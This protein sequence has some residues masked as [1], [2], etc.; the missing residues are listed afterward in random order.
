MITFLLGAGASAQSLPIGN[1]LPGALSSLADNLTKKDLGNDEENAKKSSLIEDL[2]WLAKRAELHESVDSFAKKVHMHVVDRTEIF[3][4]DEIVKSIDKR[5]EYHRLKR[6]LTSFFVIMQYANVDKRYN[7]LLSYIVTKKRPFIY[8]IKEQ[9]KIITWNYDA[10]IEI[11]FGD[12]YMNSK[13]KDVFAM[14]ASYPCPYFLF[15]KEYPKEWSREQD[16]FNLSVMHLN[17][18]AGLYKRSDGFAMLDIINASSLD[19]IIRGTIEMYGAKDILLDFAWDRD[20]GISHLTLSNIRET[21]ILVIIGYSFPGFN[22]HVDNSILFRLENLKKIYIQD[23]N[24]DIIK[25]K[26]IG[27]GLNPKKIEIICEN[28]V[29]SFLIPDE[30]D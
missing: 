10:Q 28:Y 26:L 18:V 15:D 23:I 25:S 20:K 6:A 22:K 21:Q 29:D 17:G 24:A 16:I 8:G 19:E 27:R 30:L 13:T 2:F 3:K 7:R 1:S 4:Y 11:A 14:L 5:E 9:V 12:H